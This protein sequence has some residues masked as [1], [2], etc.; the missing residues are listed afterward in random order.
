L[1]ESGDIDF[2]KKPV[3]LHVSNPEQNNQEGAE[4]DD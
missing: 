1:T 2:S 4:M 3:D